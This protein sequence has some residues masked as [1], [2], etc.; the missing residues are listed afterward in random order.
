ML[1]S[2]Q[3]RNPVE[4]TGKIFKYSFMQYAKVLLPLCIAILSLTFVFFLFSFIPGASIMDFKDNE[5]T[6]LNLVNVIMI[7]ITYIFFVAVSI[8]AL[9]MINRNIKNSYFRDEAY[10]KMT[11][12]V[13]IGEHMAGTILSSMVWY[14]ILG[15]VSLISVLFLFGQPII[16]NLKDLH[17][18][19]PIQYLLMFILY[20]FIALFAL[21]AVIFLIHSLASLVH[22]GKTAVK[23]GSVIGILIISEIFMITFLR[24]RAAT[25][26]E[27]ENPLIGFY[28]PFIC[29]IALVGILSYAGSYLI[30]KK[31]YNLE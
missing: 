31:K 2:L 6:G 7:S 30:L 26:V 12:P 27:S 29:Y 15:V 18:D 5:F 4:R 11:L 22:K 13:S 19:L 25:I 10:L 3:K 16:S 28:W 17:F 20:W 14:I 8:C 24:H 9:V 21:I 1:N 23:I